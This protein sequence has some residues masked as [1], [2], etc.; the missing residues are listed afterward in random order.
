MDAL[1]L[2]LHIHSLPS[3]PCFVHPE[4]LTVVSWFILFNFV[5][6]ISHSRRDPEVKRNG[7]SGIHSPQL[8]SYRVSYISCRK[9]QSLWSCPCIWLLSLDS[10][11]SISSSQGLMKSPSFFH[12][13]ST[14][15]SLW[16]F[17][18]TL[19]TPI[20]IIPLLNYLLNAKV[21]WALCFLLRPY[22]VQT[23]SSFCFN[24]KMCI[25]GKMHKMRKIWWFIIEKHSALLV[26]LWEMSYQHSTSFLISWLVTIRGQA[27]RLYLWP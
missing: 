6:S 26:A 4:I 8:L 17:S 21:E 2:P 25:V 19:T 9:P 15:L 22:Q 1:C 14:V 12:C 20:T 27:R 23:E 7:G 24:Y 3:F 11:N 16:W 18:W 13:W 10:C 5:W